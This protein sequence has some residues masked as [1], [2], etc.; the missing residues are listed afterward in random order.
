MTS[1][2]N[3]THIDHEKISKKIFLKNIIRKKNFEKK[4]KKY[5]PK[6]KKI[7]KKGYL[8]YALVR[9]GR[10]QSILFTFENFAPQID[11]FLRFF[12]F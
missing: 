4:S 5:K 7:L 6:I 3:T 10:P 12:R 9:S 8:K 1:N 2:N 11:P